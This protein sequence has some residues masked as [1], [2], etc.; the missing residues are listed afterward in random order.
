VAFLVIIVLA[1]IGIC[2][3]QFI[4]SRNAVATTS[5]LTRYSPEQAAGIIDEA[6]GGHRSILWT[7]TQGDGRINKRRRGWRGGITMSF[8]VE[9]QQ[10]GMTR[11][12]MWASQTLVYM[13]CW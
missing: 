3:W 10:D 11:I 8:D 9:P 2:I 4:E 6:F 7:N 1:F 12:D 5:V 13:A